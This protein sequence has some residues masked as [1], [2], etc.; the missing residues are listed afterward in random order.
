MAVVNSSSQLVVNTYK[1]KEIFESLKK[2]GKLKDNELHLVEG[3][4]EF[5]NI[6]TEGS[7]NLMSSDGIFRAFQANSSK[8]LTNLE[9]EELLKNFV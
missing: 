9:I 7:E 1:S 3:E 2:Q 5:D 6:P 8:A 4:E